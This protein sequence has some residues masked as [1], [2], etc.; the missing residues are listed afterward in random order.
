MEGNDIHIGNDSAEGYRKFGLRDNSV[1]VEWAAHEQDYGRTVTFKTS[2]LD[3]KVWVVPAGALD[4]GGVPQPAYLNFRTALLTSP[5][6]DEAQASRHHLHVSVAPA[7]GGQAAP[8][9]RPRLEEQLHA[10]P[11]GPGG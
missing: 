8:E 1:S 3:M 4:E 11:A 10:L 5:A 9:R 6:G 2:T 7:A